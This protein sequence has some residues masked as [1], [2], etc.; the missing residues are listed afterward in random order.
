MYSDV[1]K[2]VDLYNMF[3][4]GRSQFDVRKLNDTYMKHVIIHG[5]AIR[6]PNYIKYDMLDQGKDIPQ[7][8]NKIKTQLQNRNG[9]K[10][11]KTISLKEKPE[12]DTERCNLDFSANKK[13]Q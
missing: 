9:G 11:E 7:F 13:T 8:L 6:N 10:H 12:L 1:T 2:V 4:E 3:W 5:G